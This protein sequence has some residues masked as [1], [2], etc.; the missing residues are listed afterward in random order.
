M[1]DDEVLPRDCGFGELLHGIVTF[2]SIANAFPIR[3]EAGWATDRV[4]RTGCQLG[5]GAGQREE[6]GSD[7]D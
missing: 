2:D 6:V 5:I 4:L 1:D 3:S 7:S